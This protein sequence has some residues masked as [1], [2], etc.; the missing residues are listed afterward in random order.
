MT[1]LSKA[2]ALKESDA[3]AKR[4]LD[5]RSYQRYRSSWQGLLPGSELADRAHLAPQWRPKARLPGR[6]P[7]P[8]G[9][10]YP[11]PE[12]QAE[13]RKFLDIVPGH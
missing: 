8:A 6:W 2:N 13:F 9:R 1:A 3:H 5:F 11:N 10:P 7:R 4:L 12:A